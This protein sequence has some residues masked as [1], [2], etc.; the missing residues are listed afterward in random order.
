[1]DEKER[2]EGRN[3]EPDNGLQGIYRKVRKEKEKKN[4]ER[5]KRQMI[6]RKGEKEI[7]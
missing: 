4:R 1:M 5:F 7:E 2:G 6:Y 3:M